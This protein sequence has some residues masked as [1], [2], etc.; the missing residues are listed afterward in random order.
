MDLTSN[1]D[2]QESYATHLFPSDPDSKLT[3]APIRRCELGRS[4]APIR[5]HV[6]GHDTVG[7]ASSPSDVYREDELCT[8][9][10]ESSAVANPKSHRRGQKPKTHQKHET[11]PES[12]VT[13]ADIRWCL[14]HP[15]RYLIRCRF[16]LIYPISRHSGTMCPIFKKEM[17]T[18]T[19]YF[20]SAKPPLALNLALVKICWLGVS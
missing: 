15:Q 6:T 5:S 3:N 13:R 17:R 12:E 1:E 2:Q 8:L 14:A 10:C 16:V 4:P 19:P 18:L 20:Q 11:Y 9:A 7:A